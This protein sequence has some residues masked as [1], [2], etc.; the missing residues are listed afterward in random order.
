MLFLKLVLQ[1]KM[2]VNVLCFIGWLQHWHSDHNNTT[3]IQSMCNVYAVVCILQYIYCYVN[4]EC[5]I[6]LTGQLLH[7]FSILLINILFIAYPLSWLHLHIFSV[8]ICTFTGATGAEQII[9]HYTL[10][11]FKGALALALL[12]YFILKLCKMMTVLLKFY[13]CISFAG[14]WDK[15]A[16][17]KC[18]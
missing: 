13:P 8:A 9:Q 3:R 18:I 7:I 10:T 15:R 14:N 11:C 5:Q 12:C 4:T 17:I 1:L 16:K 2:N 6:N